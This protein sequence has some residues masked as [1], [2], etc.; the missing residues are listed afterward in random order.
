PSTL[1][2]SRFGKA[3]TTVLCCHRGATSNTR[4]LFP[5]ER[6]RSFHTPPSPNRSTRPEPREIPQRTPDRYSPTPPDSTSDCPRPQA[7]LLTLRPVPAKGEASRRHG[8]PTSVISVVT[9][10]CGLK[11]SSPQDRRQQQWPNTALSMQTAALR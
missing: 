7:D 8:R 11:R 9:S 10:N 1:S 6:V 3:P 4:W 2:P 5:L